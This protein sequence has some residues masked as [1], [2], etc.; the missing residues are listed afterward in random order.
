MTFKFWDCIA[1]LI[2]R[3]LAQKKGQKIYSLYHCEGFS[4]DSA[5]GPR[6]LKQRVPKL[7][8]SH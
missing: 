2:A 1:F 5:C 3:D 7:S 8:L 6:S 4:S